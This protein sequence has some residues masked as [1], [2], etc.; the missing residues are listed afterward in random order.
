MIAN[1]SKLVREIGQ[2]GNEKG[3]NMG[4]IGDNGKHMVGLDV[5]QPPRKLVQAG[6]NSVID[7]SLKRF[8]TFYITNF[9]PQASTFFCGRVLKSVAY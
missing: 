1:N 5:H 8:I 4:R 2:P 3:I 9:P 6:N 7:S